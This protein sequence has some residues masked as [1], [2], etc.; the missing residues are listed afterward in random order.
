MYPKLTNRVE[1]NIGSTVRR[2]RLSIMDC[3][4]ATRAELDALLAS[5]APEPASLA[6]LGVGALAAVGV[7]RRRGKQHVSSLLIRGVCARGRVKAAE[8]E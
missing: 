5:R 7:R 2:C 8:A 1:E 6:L 3:F 4:S